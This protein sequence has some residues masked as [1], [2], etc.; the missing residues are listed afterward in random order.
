[1]PVIDPADWSI[2]RIKLKYRHELH[3]RDSQF[4][5]VRNLLDQ[6][7]KSTA[8]LRSDA[9]TWV[10]GEAAHMHFINDGLSRGFVERC[11]SLPVVSMR[12]CDHAFNGHRGVIASHLGCVATVVL[13]NNNAASVRI[14]ENLVRIETHSTQRIEGTV[15]AV[16]I[17]LSGFHARYEYVP[18][19][20]RSVGRGIDRDHAVGPSII[21]AIKEEEFDTCCVL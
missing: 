7:R 4:L 21:N 1:A 3:R 15:N 11:V 19:V 13:W 10:A 12:I 17:N 5:Q 8:F 2:L 6:A 20:I 18:I 9:G 14:D 16:T